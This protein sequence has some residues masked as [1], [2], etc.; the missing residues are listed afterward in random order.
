M[1]ARGDAGVVGRN[2]RDRQV[3]PGAELPDE[4]EASRWRETRG[5]CGDAIEGL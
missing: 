5:S 1:I 2:K 3:S 4:N